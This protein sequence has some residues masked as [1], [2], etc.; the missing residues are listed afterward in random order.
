MV[1]ANDTK[2]NPPSTFGARQ[3]LR[4]TGDDEPE[5]T[6]SLL[7][8]SDLSVVLI[9][10]GIITV[11]VFILFFMTGRDEPIDA[12]PAPG[13]DIQSLE[14]RLTSL[15]SL[16]AGLEKDAG[17]TPVSPPSL[18]SYKARVER[19]EAALSM[20]F[21]LVSNRLSVLERRIDGFDRR[22]DSQVKSSSPPK[23]AA[24]KTPSVK[25]AISKSVPSKAV[26]AAVVHKVKKGETLYSISRQ[27]NT[28]VAK[29][30]TL[31]HLT[32]KTD[33]FPGDDLVVK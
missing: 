22:L 25:K 5:K 30:R 23:A 1:K 6:T 31:N 21:D 20:K 2:D 17:S 14:A 27:Y 11:I 16:V 29:L 24:V 32:D 7:K 13:S 3:N 15:E 9:G 12:T 26:A 33:I 28:T 8:K 4:T 19:V 10:A 18:D